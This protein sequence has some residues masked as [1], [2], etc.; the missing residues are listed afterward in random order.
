[1]NYVKTYIFL[2]GVILM[3]SQ[4]SLVAD[5]VF[6]FN[7]PSRSNS[8]TIMFPSP[9]ADSV[10]ENTFTAVFIEQ[11]VCNGKPIKPEESGGPAGVPDLL[12]IDDP[13]GQV[14]YQTNADWLHSWIN[15]RRTSDS[16]FGMREFRITEE[17]KTLEIAYRVRFPN[18]TLSALCKVYYTAVDQ[19]MQKLSIPGA[20]TRF[21]ESDEIMLKKLDDEA[22]RREKVLEDSRKREA[23]GPKKR[24][25]P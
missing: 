24:V 21:L 4:R 6:H 25:A 22:L 17:I 5:G 14:V 3:S 12:V 19:V 2:V 9:R 8:W 10:Y 16:I 23:N 1:M 13:I 15:L 7:F 11:V 20:K 18:G